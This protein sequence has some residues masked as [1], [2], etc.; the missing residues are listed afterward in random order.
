[1][2][3]ARGWVVLASDASH[4]YENFLGGRAFP[5]VYNVADMLQGHR[6]VVQ[7]ADSI[8]HVVPGHDPQVLTRYPRL[9]GDDYGIAFSSATAGLISGWARKLRVRPANGRF[10]RVLV[11]ISHS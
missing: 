9:A 1:M 2:F 3:T 4:Y 7:A 8:D 6:R 5:I 11:A 10:V